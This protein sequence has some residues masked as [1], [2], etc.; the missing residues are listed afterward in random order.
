MDFKNFVII[1]N[2]NTGKTCLF[3]K[4]AEDMGLNPVGFRMKTFTVENEGII[5][6][7][8]LVK[9]NGSWRIDKIEEMEK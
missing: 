5:F 2:S 3:D 6:K 7:I 1:G 8:S 9:N 4:I